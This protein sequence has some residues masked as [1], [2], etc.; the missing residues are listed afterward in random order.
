MAFVPYSGLYDSP[1]SGRVVMVGPFGGQARRAR[2]EL[3]KTL[4]SIADRIEHLET[5]PSPPHTAQ[6][7][8]ATR[9]AIRAL[10]DERLGGV[11][12]RFLALGSDVESNAE[13]LKTLTFAVAEGIE[14]TGRAERRI[15][16]TVKRAR[17]EL[18]EHGYESPGL[19]VEAAEL[20]LVDGGGSA[21]DTLPIVPE[22]VEPLQEAP[23]SIPGVSAETLRR[24][25][26]F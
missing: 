14:R 9:D 8:E 18:A 19:E 6:Q 15:H 21:D 2:R 13:K 23:S 3:E 20:R 24:A 10:V 7:I 4:Q 11:E 26:G 5:T 12:T 17:K 22:G 16:A 1:P 25:R